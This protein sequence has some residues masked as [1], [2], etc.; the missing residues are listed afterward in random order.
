MKKSLIL[1]IS[2]CLALCMI[3]T[4]CAKNIPPE[5]TAGSQETKDAASE[6]ETTEPSATKG[7]TTKYTKPYEVVHTSVRETKALQ[8]E[9]PEL[10][11]KIDWISVSNG[12]PQV[13]QKL[14]LTIGDKRD[15]P[16]LFRNGHCIYVME[17]WMMVP[18]PNF[19]I[20]S[21]SDFQSKE[22]YMPTYTYTGTETFL[23]ELNDEI[24]YVKQDEWYFSVTSYDGSMEKTFGSFQ[25]M[26]EELP[27]GK[28]YVHFDITV[29]GNDIVKE[30]GEVCGR[31]F[32]MIIPAFILE[33]Q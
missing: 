17:D 20:P 8:T 11:E 1:L 15:V 3:F 31:E 7:S 16:Y 5:D 30:N 25:Q 28:Y 6:G 9:I 21:L 24:Y 26:H 27:K 14:V 32:K 10:Q 23:I 29:Y 12:Y 13:Q 33:L 18:L 4:A 19:S 22:I 2:F